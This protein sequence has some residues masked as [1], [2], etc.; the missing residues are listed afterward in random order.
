MRSEVLDIALEALESLEMRSLT[1]G[2]VDQSLGETEAEA[3]IETALRAKSLTE[4]AADVLDALRDAALVR[5]LRGAG[6]RRYRTRIAELIRLLSRLRQWFNGQ[7][8]QAAPTL[9]SD[10]RVDV[11]PRR[12]PRRNITPQEAWGRISVGRQLSPLQDQIWQALTSHDPLF[13]L[14]EF[15]VE[16]SRRLL[17]CNGGTGTI[18]TAGTGSGKTLAF[19]L[20][21]LISIVSEVQRGD[22]W[23]KAV[24]LYPR[25]ELLKDQLSEAYALTLRAT[26]ALS[27]NGRRPLVLGSLFGP[28]PF[29]ASEEA[30][31]QAGWVAR[32]DGYVCPFLR[33]PNCAA[34]MVWSKQMIGLQRE[35]LACSECDTR[36][37]GMTLRLTRQAVSVQPPDLLFTTTEMMNQ[38][39][40][41]TR[42]RGVFG[43]GKHAARQPL[44]ALLDEAHTYAGISGAQV[45]LLLRRWSALLGSRL[46]WAGL[47]ATLP[48]A[49]T[50][51]ADLTGTRLDQVACVA[52]SADDMISEGAEYNII[53][54][55][56]PSSQ[57]ATLSTSIQTI[58][59]LSR[60]L[61]RRDRDLSGG[62]FGSRTFVF[63]D[64]LDVTHRLFDN[65]LDA[66]AYNP[67]RR[68]DTARQPLASL[69]ASTQ[70]DAAERELY[71]QRWQMAED[72]RSSLADR[73]RIGRTTSRDPGVDA[74]ADVIV[75]TSSLEVGFND[76]YVGAVV[77]HKAPRSAASFLQR[78]GRAGRPR[79]MRPLT[80]IVLSDYGRDRVAFQ[81]Y[82][83]LFDPTVEI[84]ALPVR[85]LYVLRMQA[86]YS[87]LEWIAAQA[88]GGVSGWIWRVMTG[89]GAE[90]DS[91]AALRDHAKQI[92][93]NVL[94]FDGPTIGRLRAHLEQALR[95]DAEMLD[96]VLW[97]PPRPLLL[98]ALPT[99]GRRLFRQW[100]LA[101]GDGFDL[102]KPNPP[103]PLP[104]FIPANLFSDLNLPEVQ[105]DVPAPGPDGQLENM[106]I[107]QALQQFAP[108]RVTR[109]FADRQGKVSHWFPL[110]LSVPNQ[111]LKICA[112]SP[113][114]E[115]VGHRGNMPI[116]RPWRVPLATV[117]PN[118][119]ES[120]N[121][122]WKWQSDFDALGDPTLVQL[123][124][125][126]GL[127]G[128]AN[129]LEFRLHRFGSAVSVRRFAHEG[130]AALSVS[131]QERRITFRLVD[132]CDEPAA[133]GFAF[134]A[135]ALLVP[136]RLPAP[137]VLASLAL[138]PALMRWLRYLA[139]ARGVEI[140]PGLPAL[141]YFRR[142]WLHQVVL[143]TALALAERAELTLQQA[144][145]AL[146]DQGD[147]GAFTP[148][149]DALVS[150]T[151]PVWDGED[152]DADDASG[153]SASTANP[154]SLR[155]QRLRDGLVQAIADPGVMNTL[156]DLALRWTIPSAA[157]WGEWLAEIGCMTVG[158]A[159]YQACITAAPRNAAAEGLTVDVEGG[160]EGHR[161][162]IAET[163]LGGGGTVEA[164]A[165]VFAA[166]PRAFVR[167]L[168]SACAPSDQEMAAEELR[169]L[170]ACLSEDRNLADALGTLR[171]AADTD[172]RDHARREFFR[173]LAG[174]NIPVSRTLSVSIAARLVRPGTSPDSDALSLDL[175]RAWQSL[176]EKY[177]IALPVRMAAAA[178]AQSAP[179]QQSLSAFGGAG[180]EI[181]TA[182][183]LLLPAGCELRQRAL[184]SYNPFRRAPVVDA[185]LARHLLFEARLPIVTIDDPDW[186]PQIRKELAEQG[187]VRLTT[188]LGDQSWRGAIAGVLSEPIMSG[189]LQFYPMIEATRVLGDAR[190][191][192]DLVL[193]DRV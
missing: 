115:Y 187:I 82:E 159:V 69:R 148:A 20:P 171:T 102:H 72:L 147:S 18:I 98:D 154:E 176:E 139:F 84:Q 144:L 192:I 142:E 127:S 92:L 51:F 103:H 26:A 114:H 49:A 163:T 157:D 53:L 59:L 87:A 27:Q 91:Q 113:R 74:V 75:A 104:D 66:E 40:S 42:M 125:V 24:C 39:L 160:A 94:K 186:L 8:W 156:I 83:H 28:T 107:V 9:V 126:A 52:P 43:V 34:D 31:S 105:I 182:G 161:A 135:D 38:R 29:T 121:A 122:Q 100:R 95:L 137:A 5:A 71:G 167:A 96:S 117:P 63:T 48:Q 110:D 189:Y 79:G 193:R 112:Y 152:G 173:L 168:E 15:Q 133:V 108:G 57:T 25:Q 141:N 109:R 36:T 41:D 50:F 64:D 164:L 128:A 97:Q 165:E 56:D 162:I 68:P 44:F 151:L 131:R 86:V 130:E 177:G 17:S 166:D 190:F 89:P 78:R 170:V 70:P 19:Y 172:A 16:A 61:D 124:S 181:V 2:F 3:A 178:V 88:P 47:S 116:F 67:W 111:H 123:P 77:Q 85:N 119:S 120:S 11:R 6:E 118:V 106:P 62:R 21:A 10:F 7:S 149:I 138:P 145:Q 4:A 180:K 58:M 185:A 143:L 188:G 153:D 129:R 30:V 54:R 13:A 45:A 132:D 183:M 33:C 99:L 155:P 169:R 101:S 150:G 23:T 90:N 12:Y 146:R 174:H 60:M 1:W 73:L 55:S 80:V 65:L 140:E 81:S 32:P 175:L 179:L 37:D 184:Q 191:A 76:P 22:W 158:E 14:S 136:F 35:V 134:E 93:Q 46:R